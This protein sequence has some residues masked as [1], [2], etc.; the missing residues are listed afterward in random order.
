MLTI[1]QKRSARPLPIFKPELRQAIRDGQKTQT[2]RVIKSQPIGDFAG[3][4]LFHPSVTNKRGDMR[5]GPEMFG[6]WDTLGKWSIRCPYGKPGDIAYLRE[7]F[8]CDHAAFYPCFPIV[9]RD[10][11]SPGTLPETVRGKTYSPE[12]KAW[13][14]FKWRS[15]MMFPREMARTFVRITD[16]CVERL[17]DISDRDAELEGVAVLERHPNTEGLYYWHPKND[18][19]YTMCPKMA[20]EWLWNSING[21]SSWFTNPFVWV[22]K[23]DP[24]V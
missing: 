3:P 18:E 22:I 17:Q 4:D 16:I 1:E 5:P 14:P 11:Y 10:D 24:I 9:Y 7:P 13:Y 21:E 6:I 20:F 8:T 12:Q 15:S 23:W 2:R 19:F